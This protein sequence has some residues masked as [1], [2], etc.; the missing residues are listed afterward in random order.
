MIAPAQWDTYAAYV[1]RCKDECE[2]PADIATWSRWKYPSLVM[3]TPSLEERVA[4]LEKRMNEMEG[5][6]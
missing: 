4:A 1:A 3:D 6:K 2:V 5:G